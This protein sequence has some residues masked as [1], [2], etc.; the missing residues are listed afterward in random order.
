MKYII[1]LNKFDLNIK[2]FQDKI[3][4][5]DNSAKFYNDNGLILE[6]NLSLNKLSDREEINKIIELYTEWIE[7]VS[8]TK[9]KEDILKTFKKSKINGTYSVK[10]NFIS[11]I[12][13][14]ASSIYKKF[15]S[16][17][18]NN[19][20]YSESPDYTFYIEF[21]KKN[22]KKYYRIGIIKNT[23]IMTYQLNNITIVLE[24]P[25]TIEEISDFLS[26]SY[27]FK[28]PLILMTKNNDLVNKAKK[29]TKN[30]PYEKL[31]LK[32]TYDLPKDCIKLGFSKH[33][34]DNELKLK[35]IYLK[36]KNKKLLLIFGNEKYGLSQELRDKLDYS[37]HLTPEFKKPLKA[38]QALSYVIGI[39]T[40]SIIS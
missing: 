21:I 6:T 4:A 33:S 28:L 35:E 29:L 1:F 38:S 32:L 31:N 40:S 26:L 16:V 14:S 17:L 36:N 18:K 37:F 39:F 9:L 8:F 10:T 2:K 3:I 34:K 7:L 20:K 19:I 23:K 11:P 13:I 15:N 22:N 24:N 27:I 25:T 30:V 12:P 5:I